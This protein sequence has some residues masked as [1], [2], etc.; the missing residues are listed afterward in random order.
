[1]PRGLPFTCTQGPGDMLLLP[2]H[3]GHATKNL[4][5]NLGIGDLYCDVRFANRSGDPHCRTPY[6]K[7]QLN[8]RRMDTGAGRSQT[9]RWPQMLLHAKG[10][11]WVDPKH[12]PF[13]HIRHAG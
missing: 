6:K 5:F 12:A 10:E 1:M 13:R 3:W 7:L 2:S 9:K 4:G 8:A 11:A